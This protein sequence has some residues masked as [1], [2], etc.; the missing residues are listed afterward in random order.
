[1][2][3]A[4]ICPESTLM[5]ERGWLRTAHVSEK[6][7]A[8]GIDRHGRAEFQDVSFE[9]ESRTCQLAFIGSKCGFGL[10]VED[11][12]ILEASG[13][14]MSM[15]ELNKVGKISEVKFETFTDVNDTVTPGADLVWHQLRENRVGLDGKAILLARRR[16]AGADADH[17]E[18]V[19]YGTRSY[20]R[21]SEIEFSAAFSSNWAV[22]TE[23]LLRC[24]FLQ[25]DGSVRFERDDSFL[26]LWFWSALQAL[27]RPHEIG[28]DTM[29][30]TSAVTFTESAQW[31]AQPSAG[32]CATYLPRTVS[33]ISMAWADPTWKPICSGFLL[34]ASNPSG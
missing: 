19:E 18:V 15:A 5:G 26:A 28:F 11:S 24:C 2:P 32:S 30:H 25:P 34:A 23:N 7:R 20:Y 3:R 29:Q 12:V 4:L 27:S 1:M 10:L 13:R 8:L 14:K 31:R 6:M 33:V 21:V 17:V 16:G 22:T 9:Q